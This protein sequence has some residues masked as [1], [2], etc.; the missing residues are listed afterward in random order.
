MMVSQFYPPVPGGQEQYVRNLSRELSAR[1][2]SVSVATIRLDGAQPYTHDG[3]VHVHRIRTGAQRF[4]AAFTSERQFAP[5]LPDPEAAVHLRRVI[6]AERP[7]VIHVHD[8]LGRSALPRSARGEAP[9]V[10]TL[11]DYSSICA[12]KRLVHRGTPCSGPAVRKCLGCAA[13]HYG[14]LKG[15][16]TALGNWAGAVAE[17]H[18]VAMFLPVSRA[19]ARGA[20]LERHGLPF[21][22]IPNFVPDAIAASEAD[23]NGAS[24]RVPG[25]GFML[26]VGD[27]TADK[28]VH[29]LLD[30]YARLAAPP[31]LVLIGRPYIPIDRL[32]PGVSALGVLPS[33]AV[34]T[35][36]RRSLIGVVPSIVPDS[37]PTVVMEAMA[38]GR[39]VVASRT[40]G[41]PDLVEDGRTGILV[42]P[43]AP[44]ALAGA[45]ERLIASPEL[46]SRM[47]DAA[48]ANLS[49]FTA[50]SVVPQIERIYEVAI[51]AGGRR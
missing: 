14:R 8:W 27:L 10:M 31:K 49:Q 33:T 41:I 36:W 44:A 32:P 21:R 50:S 22:V 15:P 29:V 51:G 45:L 2:H 37:C 39:P 1:G 25:R 12:Q 11:H 42:E 47:S 13:H 34:M 48:R 4:P 9:V 46:R 43:N 28:G 18:S 35:A 6:R 38:A 3:E 5:P 23:D 20:Q 16:P 19:V 24:A 30:A 17:R 7:D 26:F 40:G